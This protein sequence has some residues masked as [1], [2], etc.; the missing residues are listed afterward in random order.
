MFGIFSSVKSIARGRWQQDNGIQSPHIPGAI[1][2]LGR[3]LYSASGLWVGIG[4]YVGYANARTPT[5]SGPTLVRPGSKVIN[6]IDRPDRTPGFAGAARRNGGSGGGTAAS[7]IP[8][9]GAISTSVPNA[10]GEVNPV[11]GAT[12]GRLDQ[13]F[14]VTGN[15]FVSPFPGRVVVSNVSDPGWKGGGYVAIQSAASHSKVIYFAEGIRPTVKV[16]QT[17][18]AGQDIGVPVSN[19]YNGIRGNIEFGPANPAN[20]SQ[21]LAQ[22]T[23][24]KAS[25]VMQFYVWVRALG[26]PAATSTGNAGYP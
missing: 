17:V 14:D 3:F 4:W 2:N 8:G 20:P 25:T 12:G 10:A 21:P 11:P 18:Q 22:V 13:G 5:G 1:T 26:A 15:K 19:P 6:S 23:S 24:A 9:A 16:G 7:K